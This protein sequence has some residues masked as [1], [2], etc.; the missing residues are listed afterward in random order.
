MLYC[1]SYRILHTLICIKAITA[2]Y[3]MSLTA[4]AQGRS[5]CNWKTSA[6]AS[7]DVACFNLRTVARRI[8]MAFCRQHSI[9][10]NKTRQAESLLITFK[11]LS[12][13]FAYLSSLNTVVWTL[14]KGKKFPV[15]MK[16]PLEEYMSSTS[17]DF[18]SP[19]PHSP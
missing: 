10:K 16:S 2:F 11:E 8:N 17:G 7:A 6:H 9:A 18:N 19:L 5:S 1:F 13:S 3:N 14:N 15:I 4:Q 12:Y